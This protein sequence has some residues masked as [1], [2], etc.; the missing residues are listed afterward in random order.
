[1]PEIVVSDA[2]AIRTIR[3]DRPEK[4]NALTLP[5]Y[6]AM[7]H[8]IEEA[9]TR[10]DVRCLLIAGHESGFCA[11]NDLSDFLQMA[12]AGGLGEPIV[13]FLHALARRETPLVAAVAGKAVGIGTTMLLH[14]DYVVAAEDAVLSTPFVALGLAP[15]AASSLLGPRLMGDARAFELLVMGHPLE[16]QAAKAAGIVN[17]VVPA[18]ELESAALAAAREIA[19]L[20]PQGVLAA[21]ALLRGSADEIAARIDAEVEVFRQRLTSPEARA[22]FMAFFSRKK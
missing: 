6:A 11:G 1:M 17:A 12:Q 3:I 22:A 21:R 8:A 4:K 14:C 15:E 20:P 13:R 16:A 18:A 19:N 10:A 2:D 7:A 5:M 9:N